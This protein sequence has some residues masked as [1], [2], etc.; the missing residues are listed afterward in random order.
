[1]IQ[2]SKSDKLKAIKESLVPYIDD[3]QEALPT[4]LNKPRFI[5]NCM[6]VLDG[7]QDLEKYT[8]ASIITTMTK[9][10][11]L[12]LDFF[13]G[14]AYA[15][16]YGSALSFQTSYKGEVK[17]VKKYSIRAIKDVYAKVVKDGDEYLMEEYN[18]RQDLTFKPLAFNDGEIKGAFAIVTYV[19]GGIQIEEMSK[20]DIEDVRKK[21]SKQSA[22]KAWTNSYGEMCRKTVLRRLCKHI[23]IDFANPEQQKAFEDG[24]SSEFNKKKEDVVATSSLDDVSES[25]KEDVIEAE[26]EDKDVPPDV[27]ESN[28]ETA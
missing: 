13:Q 1:M 12:G 11:F 6:A 3:R 18:G 21:Y 22:G 9:G 20:K 28:K 2:V 14:E 27:S 25:N 19:D 4:D 8:S 23:N 15:I 26:F 7:V 5:Q 17:L 10:A 16:P 24:G